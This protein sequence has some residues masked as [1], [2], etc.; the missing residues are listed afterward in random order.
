SSRR[1]HTRFSRDWSSDVCS[2]DL[3]AGTETLEAAT[4]AGHTHRDTHVATSLEGEL[5]GD[6]LADRIDRAGPVDRD[7]SAHAPAATLATT[8][9]EHE[10]EE[11]ESRRCSHSSPSPPARGRLT[12]ASGRI[13]LWFVWA[14][15][16]PRA[17]HADRR[18]M[19]RR[20]HAQAT[21]S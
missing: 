9:P 20:G 14:P 11:H 2:S 3:L 4:G 12:G 13:S 21:G 8:R 17:P 7:R 18:M 6:R 1:R 19:R 15:P 10:C 16:N 5:L